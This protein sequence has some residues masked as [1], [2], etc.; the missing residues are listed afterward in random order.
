MPPSPSWDA[1]S[2]PTLTP[3]SRL[4][5]AVLDPVR[6]WTRNSVQSLYFSLMAA[7]RHTEKE[8]HTN[9][10]C[11]KRAHSSGVVSWWIINC[12]PLLSV[13]TRERHAGVA[14]C[15]C[16]HGHTAFCGN[17]IECFVLVR[18]RVQRLSFSLTADVKYFNNEFDH[19]YAN[20]TT[21][22]FR[23]ST[24]LF[25]E[26]KSLKPQSSHSRCKH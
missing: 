21:K 16:K 26:K 19:F 5:G 4:A 23:Y 24:S 6:S 3:S 14:A 7:K 20:D 11:V 25:L 22:I 13:V 2:G 18:T 1:L 15:M 17:T 9:N 10:Q 12:A 8:K